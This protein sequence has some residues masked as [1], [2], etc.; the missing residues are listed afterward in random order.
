[1]LKYQHEESWPPLAWLASC[2]ENDRS[3]TIRHGPDVATRQDWFCEAVW[4]DDYANG[5]IDQTSTVFG[6]GG[7]IRDGQIVFVSSAF[8]GDGLRHIKINGTQYVS[9]SLVCLAAVLDLDVDPCR[10]VVLC[11]AKVPGVRLGSGGC[12]GLRH[13]RRRLT[14]DRTTNP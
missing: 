2:N 3:I 10:R 11:P 12:E 8:P 9:N 4:D 5:N 13:R 6:T 7:R 14:L 1:M